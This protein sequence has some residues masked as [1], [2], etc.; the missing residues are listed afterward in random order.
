MSTPRVPERVQWAVDLIDVRP[1]DHILEVGC[2][3]GHAV[4]LVC[5][6][7]TR[8]SI[9]AIDRSAIAISRTRERVRDHIASGRARVERATLGNAKLG[10]RFRK[11][12]AINVNAFWTTPAASIPALVRLLDLKGTAWLVYEPP[13]VPRLRELGESLPRELE[14]HGFE[15]DRIE[16]ERFRSSSGLAIVCRPRRA[17]LLE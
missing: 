12:F 13:S 2:G 14:S 17:L 1:A 16:T 4:A 10:R 3:P 7:L 6:R 15:V 11:V 9:T 5:E 8:G